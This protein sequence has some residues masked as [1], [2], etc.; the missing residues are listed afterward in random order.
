MKTHLPIRNCEKTFRFQ[1]PKLWT[2]LAATKISDVRH[3][4]ICN[5][6]VHF[7]VTDEET[8]EHAKAGHCIAREIPDTGQRNVVVG[9]PN[10]QEKK[11]S[12]EEVEASKWASRERGIDDSIRNIDSA[13]C[14][15]RCNYPAPPWRIHCRV[16]GY[17]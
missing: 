12:P 13:R 8:V 1:C 2:E 4:S 9:M 15:A 7:C 6:D 10:I 5:R 3:C 14:C 17:E 16:C 11:Q